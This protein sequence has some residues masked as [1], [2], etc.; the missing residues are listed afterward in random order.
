MTRCTP[1]HT[2]EPVRRAAV[3]NQVGVIEQDLNWCADWCRLRA[4]AWQRRGGASAGELGWKCLRLWRRGGRRGRPPWARRIE[5]RPRTGTIV[6]GTFGSPILAEQCEQL[7]RQ[8]RLPISAP[9]ASTH[10][11]NAGG[12]RRC[13]DF[14][15]RDFA[16][17]ASAALPALLTSSRLRSN[18]S[19]RA[20]RGK[21]MR[22][23]TT[24]R[25]NVWV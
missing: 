10:S 5:C 1:G 21:G 20:R 11:Q 13:G 25:W 3:A 6:G 9:R 18:G 24:F 4:G 2:A 17:V 14:E 8:Q 15:L 22:S 16:G 12:A 19:F 7:R 23:M